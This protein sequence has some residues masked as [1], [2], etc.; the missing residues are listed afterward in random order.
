MKES[1]LNLKEQYDHLSRN[2]QDLKTRVIDEISSRLDV[3]G[4]SRSII[5]GGRVIIVEKNAKNTP[6]VCNLQITRVLKI[7]KTRIAVLSEDDDSNAYEND[8]RDLTLKECMT[9]LKMLHTDGAYR[10]VPMVDVIQRDSEFDDEDSK[11]I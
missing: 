2:A 1:Y 9:I 7:G 8:I 10:P 11:S 3:V 5:A 4:E 6:I